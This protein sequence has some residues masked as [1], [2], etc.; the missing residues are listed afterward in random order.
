MKNISFYTIFILQLT[1]VCA[2]VWW[3]CKELAALFKDP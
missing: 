1:L 3:N 2:A